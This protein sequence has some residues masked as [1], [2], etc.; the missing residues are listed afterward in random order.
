MLCSTLDVAPDVRQPQGDQRWL[1]D[2]KQLLEVNWKKKPIS[3]RR[4]C[5]LCAKRPGWALSGAILE[6]TRILPGMVWRPGREDVVAPSAYL[7]D[8]LNAVQ[9]PATGMPLQR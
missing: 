6:D 4:A 3:Y 2:T 7:G 8:L 5:Y 1:K 9:P